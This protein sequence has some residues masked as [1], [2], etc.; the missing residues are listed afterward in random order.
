MTI[1]PISGMRHSNISF[2][3]KH[4]NFSNCEKMPVLT[5]EQAEEKDR[6]LFYA[7]T[8]VADNL[9]R[10]ITENKAL[11]AENKELRQQLSLMA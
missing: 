6:T 5:T 3:K 8:C 10:K 7:L 11:K 4:N 1:T 9:A 2:S